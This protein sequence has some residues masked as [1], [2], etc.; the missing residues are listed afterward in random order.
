VSEIL[1]LLLV[2]LLPMYSWASCLCVVVPFGIHLADVTQLPKHVA[3]LKCPPTKARYCELSQRETVSC[4]AQDIVTRWPCHMA[5]FGPRPTV[6]AV[7][8]DTPVLRFHAQQDVHLQFWLLLLLLLHVAVGA[9]LC[10]GRRPRFHHHDRPT[11]RRSRASNGTFVR[12]Q[13]LA[14]QQTPHLAR[15]RSRW[16]EIAP[17]V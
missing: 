9:F 1:A 5:V 14:S 16:N 6:R 17:P 4:T 11:D 10:P 12:V 15:L 2:L 8:R 3:V 13:I 7:P